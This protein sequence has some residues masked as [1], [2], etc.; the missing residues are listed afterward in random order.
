[1]ETDSRRRS[2]RLDL[3]TTEEERE[4]I[5][6]AAATTGVVLS[7]FVISQACD[8]AKRILADRDRFEL[9]ASAVEEWEAI[10]SRSVRDLPGLRRLMQKPSPFSE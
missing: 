4:L 6:R 2:R 7:Q 9:D 10:N 8:A 5:V 3:R 1:M